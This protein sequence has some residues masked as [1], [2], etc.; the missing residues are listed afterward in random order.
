MEIMSILETGY[1]PKILINWG[2]KNP[3]KVLQNIDNNIVVT[4]NPFL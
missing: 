1:R 4:P 2:D 3:T